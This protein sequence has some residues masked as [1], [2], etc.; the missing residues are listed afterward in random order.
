MTIFQFH[1]VFLVFSVTQT[2]AIFERLSNVP[3]C[4]DRKRGV[5]EK[6]KGVNYSS[7]WLIHVTTAKTLIVQN[8]N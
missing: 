1:M 4:H 8:T 7:R 2:R 3:Y 5:H 6:Q